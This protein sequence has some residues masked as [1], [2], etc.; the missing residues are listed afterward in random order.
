[1]KQRKH[2]NNFNKNKLKRKYNNNFN[3]NI[4]KRK[5]SEK[6]RNYTKCKI[7]VKKHDLKYFFKVLYI[8]ISIPGYLSLTVWF[9]YNMNIL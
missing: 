8:C 3:K 2:N 9:I 4:L 6:Q 7:P 1:M 5:R